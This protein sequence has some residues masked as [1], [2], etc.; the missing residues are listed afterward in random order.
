ML[1]FVKKLDQDQW[2]PFFIFIFLSKNISNISL[3][4]EFDDID[5]NNKR[6]GT[7]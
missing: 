2:M 5:I 3:K 7:L 6:S 1:K 4:N